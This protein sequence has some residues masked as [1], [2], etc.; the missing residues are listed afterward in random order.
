MAAPAS[1][2]RRGSGSAAALAFGAALALVGLRGTAAFALAGLPVLLWRVEG[3]IAILV[4]LC[5]IVPYAWTW[6]IPGGGEW[7]FTLPVY[8]LFL[9]SAAAAVE[10]AVRLSFGMLTSGSRRASLVSLARYAATAALL[11]ALGV[12]TFRWL[13]WLRV[14]EAVAQRRS[15]LIEP[16]SPGRFFFA[17]GWE[18]DRRAGRAAT[19][20]MVGREARLRLPLPPN[21]GAR[22][23]LRVGA[24]PPAARPVRILL[25]DVPVGSI[26][27][28]REGGE[29]ATVDLDARSPRTGGVVELRF[30][31]S[32]PVNDHP[33]LSL[34]WVRLEP[35]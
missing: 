5:S 27:D 15:A 11:T 4:F 21:L 7:R 19:A 12:W 31:A 28:S 10:G 30:I 35:L 22:V 32:G 16:G 18:W 26:S 6:N 14:G 20:S 24:A 13:D 29:V 9:I 34:L 8:P 17:S 23:V 2:G 3:V 25:G 33:S 1:R